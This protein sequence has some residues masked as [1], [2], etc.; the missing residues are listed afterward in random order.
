ML[1]I[2]LYTYAFHN[3]HISVNR[4]YVTL[5][6]SA[7]SKVLTG[8]QITIQ[9]EQYGGIIHLFIG[10]GHS[11]GKSTFMTITFIHNCNINH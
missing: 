8:E 6:P 9:C 10:T 3:I 7:C 11:P 2:N 4:I 1:S 5:I